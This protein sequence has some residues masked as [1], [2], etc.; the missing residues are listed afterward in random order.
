V[1]DTARAKVRHRKDY[2]TVA[3]Q[4]A[5]LRAWHQRAGTDTQFAAYLQRIRASNRGRPAFLD[6]LDKAQLP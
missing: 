1:I 3:A 5:Q 6:E 4:L 2:A